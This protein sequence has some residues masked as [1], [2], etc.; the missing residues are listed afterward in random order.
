MV[1]NR[2]GRTTFPNSNSINGLHVER[3]VP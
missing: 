3:S 2:Q 1:N